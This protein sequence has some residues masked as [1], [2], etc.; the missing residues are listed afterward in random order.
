MWVENEQLTVKVGCSL[1]VVP[2]LRH[3]TPKA[4]Y[5]RRS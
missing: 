1:K 5:V 2:K 3:L 4:I